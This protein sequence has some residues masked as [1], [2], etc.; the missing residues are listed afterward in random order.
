MSIL[1]S[2]LY[3]GFDMLYKSEL[4]QN[5]RT[6][7][8][9]LRHFQHI[10][11]RTQPSNYE[12][13]TMHRLVYGM[14]LENPNKFLNYIHGT[15]LACLVLWTDSE[16]I[17]R[18]FNLRQY[19]HIKRN[20][21]YLSYRVYRNRNIQPISNGVVELTTIKYAHP[22]VDFIMSASNETIPAIHTSECHDGDHTL[23]TRPNDSEQPSS[24]PCT[25]CRET[26]DDMSL[27]HTTNNIEQ[28]FKKR[29]WADE[30]ENV[31][32]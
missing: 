12:E 7:E 13:H 23:S 4:C 5:H 28:P 11:N 20:G 3:H 27:H 19:V 31:N 8:K 17:V 22:I 1:P 2:T 18:V 16:S 6:N 30:S 15:R 32:D 24:P 14:Y 26:R 10:L 9:S 29:S 21:K 25:T